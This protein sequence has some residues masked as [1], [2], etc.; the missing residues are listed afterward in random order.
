MDLCFYLVVF[1]LKLLTMGVNKNVRWR[2]C[3]EEVNYEGL[4]GLVG[5]KGLRNIG[6]MAL[7]RL[8]K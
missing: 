8:R 2:I 6:I 3:F 4:K 1:C 7:R 5:Q